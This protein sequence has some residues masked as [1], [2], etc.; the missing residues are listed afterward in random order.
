MADPRSKAHPLRGTYTAP[1]VRR[2]DRVDCLVRDRTVVVVDWSDAPF[3]W[4]RGYTPSGWGGGGG[5]GLVVTEELARALRQ[6]SA[7]AF[8]YW[9]G[10]G[11]STVWKWRAALGITRKD[12]AGT[13]ELVRG[14]TAV[15]RDVA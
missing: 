11:H 2:G 1:Q 6:E 9:W 14:A 5:A 7:Q 13:M 3:P 10:V 12:N 4:P 15:A 8:G